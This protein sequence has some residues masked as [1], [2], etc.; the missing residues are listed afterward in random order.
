MPRKWLQKLW[1]VSK[2]SISTIWFWWGIGITAFEQRSSL[3]HF[4]TDGKHMFGYIPE[5]I[6]KALL[7][8]LEEAWTT[9]NQTS[10]DV[11][12]FGLISILKVLDWNDFFLLLLSL[13]VLG[14]SGRGTMMLIPQISIAHKSGNI[15]FGLDLVW[16]TPA[17]NMEWYYRICWS[18]AERWCELAMLI[19]VLEC[20]N[21]RQCWG[22]SWK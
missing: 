6:K 22:L 19:W 9:T 2:S 10:T 14:L 17:R 4:C 7:S 21:V 16:R 11:G 20:K 13:K 8:S 18:Q 3:P 1:L 12:V 5:E 15:D